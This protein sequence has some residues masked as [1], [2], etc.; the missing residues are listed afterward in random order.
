MESVKNSY[1]GSGFPG[2][3]LKRWKEFTLKNGSKALFLAETLPFGDDLFY[4]NL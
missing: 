2:I 3:F 1:A 4:R